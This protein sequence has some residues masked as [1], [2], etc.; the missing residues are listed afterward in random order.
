MAE[1]ARQGAS[2]A[3][4][5]FTSARR[6]LVRAPCGLPPQRAG[7]LYVRPCTYKWPQ[8]G[9]RA[10][11]CPLGHKADVEVAGAQKGAATRVADRLLAMPS[12]LASGVIYPGRFVISPREIRSPGGRS[13]CGDERPGMPQARW[14]NVFEDTLQI[15]ECLRRHSSSYAVAFRGRGRFAGIQVDSVPNP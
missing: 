6:P 13:N 8:G 7:H 11:K 4:W 2:S 10:L 15:E 12:S 1:R 9:R 5:P 3:L 14:K